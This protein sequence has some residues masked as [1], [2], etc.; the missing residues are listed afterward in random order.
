MAFAR[1][2]FQTIRVYLN[3]KALGIFLVVAVA[4]GWSTG[5][6]A[7]LLAVPA[8]MECSW[9][10]YPCAMSEKANLDTL[11]TTLSLSRRTVVRGRYVFALLLVLASLA[12][13]YIVAAALSL[14]RRQP[15]EPLL[16]L[17]ELGL[18]FAVF[19]VVIA[20]QL[21]IIFKLGYTAARFLAY[22]PMIGMIVVIVGMGSLSQQE[23]MASFLT[24][25]ST[26]LLSHP[27][28]VVAILVLVW[29][30]ALL[31]SYAL[32]VRFYAKRDF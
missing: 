10:T 22:V 12:G 4:V 17:G 14:V 9:A 2:D 30:A 25:A 5:S 28:A 11:Y 8:A 1:L 26:W 7:A 3:L 29:A 6:D 18:L 15:F 23:W 13:G 27:A 19:S 16:P 21:P 20:A 24:A 32:S 31:G